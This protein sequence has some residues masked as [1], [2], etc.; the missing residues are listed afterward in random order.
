M[1][2]AGMVND[3]LTRCFRWRELGGGSER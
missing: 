1:Q 2:A 3:H